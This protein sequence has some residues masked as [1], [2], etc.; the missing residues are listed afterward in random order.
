V[1]FAIEYSLIVAY[2]EGVLESI[3]GADYLE[4][5]RRTPRWV[6]GLP[7]AR[8]TGPHDWGEAW[9][10]EI[11]T[12]MQYVAIVVALWVKQKLIGSVG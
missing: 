11:S 12:F 5:K 7:S 8:E 9:K 2:E 4:Y 1:I 3:F 6:P 10:S